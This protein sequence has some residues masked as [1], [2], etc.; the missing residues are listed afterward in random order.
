MRSCAMRTVPVDILKSLTH[1]MRFAG[2]CT[3]RMRERAVIRQPAALAI[4]WMCSCIMHTVHGGHCHVIDQCHALCR[5]LR[6]NHAG[7]G[8][9]AAARSFEQFMETTFRSTD[10]SAGAS[11]V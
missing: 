4:S 9:E 8:G 11:Q 10:P 5:R 7:E 3:E 6:G 1:V 2:G